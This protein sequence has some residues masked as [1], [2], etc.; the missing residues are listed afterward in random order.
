MDGELESIRAET[1]RLCFV[2]GA[3]AA[4]KSTLC[5]RLAQELP[6]HHVKASELVRFRRDPN[7][8][9]GKAVSEPIETQEGIIQALKARRRFGGTIL[10]DGHYC[11]LDLK[12]SIVP[13]PVR[14][15]RMIG[16]DALLL[17]D[18]EPQELVVRLDRRDGGR[19]DSG[20]A[21]RLLDAERR[22]SRVVAEALGI[23]L[24]GVVGS[25]PLSDLAERSRLILEARD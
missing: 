9:T 18:V 16:P 10:L 2:G 19:L 6:A 1:S 3:F 22:Q 13:V 8:P 25:D 11:L 15:F 4:G 14:V 12:H 23:P 5:L 21:R 17:V 20:L 24:V 7:D